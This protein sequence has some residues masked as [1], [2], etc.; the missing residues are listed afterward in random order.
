MKD[1]GFTELTAAET[2]SIDGGSFIT[3]AQQWFK[4]TIEQIV[5]FVVHILPHINRTYEEEE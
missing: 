4:R 1:Y 3:K 5:E 2:L